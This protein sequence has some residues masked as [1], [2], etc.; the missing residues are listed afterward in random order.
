MRVLHPIRPEEK[1][2]SRGQ[3][4]YLVDGEP[5]GDVETWQVSRLPGGEE[6]VRADLDG[7]EASGASL[8]THL[9]R[10]ADK[11]PNWLRLRFRSG[12]MNA[13]AQYTFEEASVRVARVAEGEQRS[14]EM[15][16][17]ATGYVVDYHT[18]ISQDYVWRGYEQA[19]GYSQSVPLFSPDLWAEDEKV[20]R[21]RALRF[22]V[23]SL[24]SQPCVIPAGEFASAQHFRVRFEDGVLA[25]AWYDSRGT[26]L[27]WHFPARGY[28]FVLGQYLIRE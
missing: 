8:V 7:R 24:P 6:I 22:E 25:E 15:I 2:V 21:G 12:Q 11:R 17:I 5:T 27:R 20:L 10:H 19:G 13:A 9:V 26:P 18:M 1:L 4:R 16:D 28:D 14:V 3:Y 23:Q